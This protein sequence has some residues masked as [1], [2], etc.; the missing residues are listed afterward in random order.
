M[1]GCTARGG[2]E[3]TDYLNH[4]GEQG[5]S[6]G[7]VIKHGEIVIL[8]D[9]SGVFEPLDELLAEHPQFT[10]ARAGRLVQQFGQPG[11]FFLESHGWLIRWSRPAQALLPA[12]RQVLGLSVRLLEI[13]SWTLRIVDQVKRGQSNE[14]GRVELKTEFPTDIAKAARQLAALANSSLGEAVLWIVGVDEKSRSVKG[15]NTQELSNWWSKIEGQ[16]DELAPSMQNVTVNVGGPVV[17]ALAFAT[18][19]APFVVKNAA[20]GQI[21]REVPWRQGNRTDSAHRSNLIQIL[22]PLVRVPK[23]EVQQASF[24][25]NL[26]GNIHYIGAARIVLYIVPQDA[27]RVVCPLHKMTISYQQESRSC[28]IPINRIHVPTGGPFGN[29]TKSRTIVESSTEIIVEGPGTFVLEAQGDL[30]FG[31]FTHEPLRLSVV[32]FDA[33]GAK[34]VTADVNLVHANGSE[35]DDFWGMGPDS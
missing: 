21:S 13:E 18:D 23:L 33:L 24:S 35:R 3:R 10:V 1:S 7:G 5:R 17:V 22:A 25:T 28:R 6:T 15:A 12:W 20:G 29:L 8:H 26:V 27:Q 4:Q 30:T 2:P 16:F 11:K 19:R 9:A 31:P 34:P 32:L 14:D